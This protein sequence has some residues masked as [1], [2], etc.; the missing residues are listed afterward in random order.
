MSR[1]EDLLVHTSYRAPDGSS[2]SPIA[3]FNVSGVSAAVKRLDT[4][5][6]KALAKPKVAVTFALTSSG[7][8]EVSKAELSLEM[9]EKYEEW[10]TVA[11]NATNANATAEE[12]AAAEPDDNTD[13][14]NAT[15]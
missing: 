15:N 4:P 9:M 7:L 8:L 5:N 6:R 11:A 14:D 13:D 2:A 12:E 3:F 1:T 10:E